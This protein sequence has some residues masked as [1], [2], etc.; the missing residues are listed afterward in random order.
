MTPQDKQPALAYDKTRMPTTNGEAAAVWLSPQQ[1][2][3]MSQSFLYSQ[4]PVESPGLDRVSLYHTVSVSTQ[5]LIHSV[6]A[7]TEEKE[8][9]KVTSRKG[10]PA[11]RCNALVTPPIRRRLPTEGSELRC[12]FDDL[13]NAARLTTL[14]ARFAPTDG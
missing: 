7:H 14:P 1:D 6:H 9:R 10:H 2:S 5:R 4:K 8:S 11:S 13:H 3:S 12:A